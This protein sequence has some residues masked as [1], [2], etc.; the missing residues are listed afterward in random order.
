MVGPQPHTFSLT[1]K[2]PGYEGQI[3]LLLKTPGA[4]LQDPS[5]SFFPYKIPPS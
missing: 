2:W 5:V 4:L 1:K 3:S